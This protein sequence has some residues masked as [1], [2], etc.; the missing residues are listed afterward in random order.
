MPH[1]TA[2]KVAATAAGLALAFGITAVSGPGAAAATATV[3][4]YTG[5]LSD[6][7]SWIAD[8]PAKWNGTLILYS[9][10]FGTLNPADS[11]DPATQADLLGEGYALVG[12]SYSGPSLWALAS[13]KEDQ[14]AALTAIKQ[15]IGR[16]KQTLALGTSMG[17]LISAQE[18]QDANGRI[19][20]A[21]T[22]CALLGGAVNLNNYQLDGEYA[23]NELL[24]PKQQIQLVD[25]MNADQSAAAIKELTA[26]VTTAQSTARG[27]ARI[28]LA[29]ALLNTPDWLTTTAPPTAKD[30]ALQEAQEAAWLPEQLAFVVG[31]RSAIESAAGG[32]GSWTV[33]VKYGALVENSAMAAQ[34]KALYRKAGL[35]L[36]ADER[37]LT[38]HANIRPDRAAVKRLTRTSTVSGHLDVPELD[39]H[40]ISDQLAPISYEN[41]YRGLVD[42]TGSGGLLRQ[43]YV[44]AI[45]HCNFTPS[46]LVAGVH[47]LQQRLASGQWANSASAANLNAAAAATGYGPSAFINYS[48]P[49]FVNARH[50]RG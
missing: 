39:L 10:G 15:K 14:F 2:N 27:R 48:P 9:H 45:G 37:R 50:Y 46:E 28:A 12:S 23:I 44:Q 5:A 11:P 26:A 42:N 43:G 41:Y 18:A 8:V 20:G 34:I 24:A 17:G 33:G 7:G 35:S 47:T 29:A 22:T 32:N 1:R 49:P 25:Y 38:N 13:A 31:S 3:T 36:S 30:Y 16:P 40:T 21:V 4:H 6:G 19:Q